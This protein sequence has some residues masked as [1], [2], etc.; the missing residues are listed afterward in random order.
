MSAKFIRFVLEAVIA[1]FFIAAF[2]LIGRATASALNGDFG[3]LQ[4]PVQAGAYG[5]EMAMSDSAMVNFTDGTLQISDQPLWHA[6]DLGFSFA[7]I[8]LFIAA[9]MVLRSV[10]TGFAQG[11]LINAENAQ[12]LRKIGHILLTVCALSVVQ[13]LVLQPAI[14]AAVTPVD[15]TV[16]HPSLS[17]DV[18]GATNIW[19]HYDPPIITFALGGLALLFSEAF[20]TGT[21]YRND[22]ESVV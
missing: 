13:A 20:K 7:T 11:E 14:L 4:W 12:A 1:L 2:L 8:A 22:S 17:W 3:V 15:G 18:Q 19:L 6:I 5:L 21:A 9:L 16:L 10:L